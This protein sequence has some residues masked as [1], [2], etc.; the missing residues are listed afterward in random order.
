MK[1]CFPW[2]NAK[3]ITEKVKDFTMLY[4]KRL[5]KRP[6][7]VLKTTGKPLLII[8]LVQDRRYYEYL[9]DNSTGNQTH[10]LIISKHIGHSK[11]Y[12]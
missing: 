7:S 2:R 3:Q 11:R 12:T 1:Q 6:C 4:D 5:F 8:D 10:F 9:L